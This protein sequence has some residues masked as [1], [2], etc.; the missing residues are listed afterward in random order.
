[1]VGFNSRGLRKEA[2]LRDPVERVRF[3]QADTLACEMPDGHDPRR[4]LDL[5]PMSDLD[6]MI[7]NGW[8]DT[9]QQRMPRDW[10]TRIKPPSGNIKPG[11]RKA[12]TS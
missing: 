7:A 1:M 6:L 4:K 12:L 5:Q 2:G 9:P 8:G 3:E 10:R 11:R